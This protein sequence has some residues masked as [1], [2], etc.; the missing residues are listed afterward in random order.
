MPKLNI[1][2]LPERL[3]KRIEQ[4]ERGDALEARD[5]NSLLN[6]EQRHALNTDWAAQQALR[7]QHTPPKTVAEK[8]QIGWKTI[9]EVRLDIYRQALKDTQDDM[10]NGIDELQRQS[11][12][13]AARTF[14]NAFSKAGK[15]DKNALSAGNIAVTRAGFNKASYCYSTKRDKEVNEMEEALYKKLEE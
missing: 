1:T 12:I 2:H 4:L 14:M 8:Q 10:L 15:E 5:I 13:K 3:M 7:K 9:R 6:N 11:E